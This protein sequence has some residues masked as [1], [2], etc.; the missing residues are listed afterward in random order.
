MMFPMDK[1]S[2]YRSLSSIKESQKQYLEKIVNQEYYSDFTKKFKNLTKKIQK[3]LRKEYISENSLK[4][5]PTISTLIFGFVED[6]KQKHALSYDFDGEVKIVNEY[7]IKYVENKISTSYNKKCPS[8]GE[9]LL[10]A[11]VDLFITTT[12][13]KTDKESPAYPDFLINPKTGSNLELDIWFEDFHIAFEFQG[14]HHYTDIKTIEKDKF[15]LTKCPTKGISL[16]P[17]N[18]SQLNS[19]ILQK[20]IVNSIKDFLQLNNLFKDKRI[21]Y[22]AEYLAQ[23]E[24]SNKQ[25]LRFSKVVQRLYLSRIIFSESLKWLDTKSDKYIT[26]CKRKYPATHS[27]KEPAPRYISTNNDFSIEDIYKNLKYVT[28]VRKRKSI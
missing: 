25:L 9:A 1:I 23:V 6:I 22:W 19:D 20:L 7:L 3:L 10:N 2:R 15:K 24:I 5:I 17:V 27:A 26:N 8:Y 18:P 14:E 21:E 12:V 4:N 28:W 11:Y 16:I 13:F